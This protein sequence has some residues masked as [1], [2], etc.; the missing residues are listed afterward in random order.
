MK[1]GPPPKRKSPSP[2]SGNPAESQPEA[3]SFLNDIKNL[4]R[5]G[6]E[7]TQPT[8]AQVLA[9]RRGKEEV[10]TNQ[11]GAPAAVMNVDEIP[12]YDSN[13]LTDSDSE[14]S[15]MDMARES[16]NFNSRMSRRATLVQSTVMGLLENAR[17]SEVNKSMSALKKLENQSVQ[18]SQINLE[19]NTSP[20]PLN[21]RR[22]SVLQ[23]RQSIQ[24]KS[25]STS[26]HS[27]TDFIRG[28]TFDLAGSS[29][30]VSNFKPPGRSSTRTGRQGS[31]EE[32][33]FDKKDIVDFKTAPSH[34][35][36]GIL[37]SAIEEHE[38]EN[39]ANESDQLSKNSGN[40][41]VIN[42]SNFTPIEES[43]VATVSN[44]VRDILDV[45]S[46]YAGPTK[47]IKKKAGRGYGAPEDV[48]N[49]V[50]EAVHIRVARRIANAPQTLPLRTLWRDAPPA[51]TLKTDSNRSGNLVIPEAKNTSSNPNLLGFAFGTAR[52]DSP[53]S[54]RPGSIEVR[55][56]GSLAVYND[57]SGTYRT[58]GAVRGAQLEPGVT[59]ITLFAEIGT[60]GNRGTYNVGIQIGKGAFM[61]APGKAKDNFSF[62]VLPQ[63]P[64]VPGE[65]ASRDGK[66]N[67]SE[68][69]ADKLGMGLNKK[70]KFISDQFSGNARQPDFDSHEL[71]SAAFGTLAGIDSDHDEDDSPNGLSSARPR[72]GGLSM[73]D[74]R[75]AARSVALSANESMGFQPSD[76][77]LGKVVM[78]QIRI[79]LRTDGKIKF[80]LVDPSSG[81]K[82]SYSTNIPQCT[83]VFFEKITNNYGAYKNIPNRSRS[84]SPQRNRSLSANRD[85]DDQEKKNASTGLMEEPSLYRT[86]NLGIRRYNP[87][88]IKPLSPTR[89]SANNTLAAHAPGGEKILSSAANGLPVSL[90]SQRNKAADEVDECEA[91]RTVALCEMAERAVSFFSDL[92]LYPGE[93]SSESHALQAANEA[94]GKT[95]LGLQA[96]TSHNLRRGV[97]DGARPNLAAVVGGMAVHTL[98]SKVIAGGGG[99]N[100]NPSMVNMGWLTAVSS[101]LKERL[102]AAFDLFDVDQDGLVDYEEL[103]EILQACGF[104][105]VRKEREDVV[106]RIDA[107]GR[108]KVRLY[109]IGLELGSLLSHQSRV[110][111]NYNTNNLNSSTGKGGIFAAAKK[112]TGSTQSSCRLGAALE[113]LAKDT[114]NS[115]GIIGGGLGANEGSCVDWVRLKDL[116]TSMR[117]SL[118]LEEIEE[119]ERDL[120]EHGKV[121]V[122]PNQAGLSPSSKKLTGSLADVHKLTSVLL[123]GVG[124][125]SGQVTTNM[126]S[127]SSILSPHRLRSGLL[128][129]S[130]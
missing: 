98:E 61:I 93:W 9:D 34:S 80:N 71:S 35:A 73:R 70:G 23:R 72:L 74:I 121:F 45:E 129:G 14:L 104:E 115:N 10:F 111:N 24:R 55:P 60:A 22:Q 41:R 12:D 16:H 79:V 86:G 88:R 91:D 116:L 68:T 120:E 30:R 33:D 7:A 56:G 110:N 18:F 49:E 58:V 6:A 109:E 124:S 100:G 112:F 102:G 82:Y 26:R 77:K 8:L 1:M 4:R 117:D 39:S 54:K 15:N 21:P 36:M 11:Y 5:S 69:L 48:R 84:T 3:P 62:E 92:R 125:L 130:K 66:G 27:V 19:G 103:I 87:C 38:S 42:K 75:S 126:G 31:D 65:E 89:P 64:I 85:R 57:F 127:S 20:S 46:A 29:V 44:A 99:G 37:N 47:N 83:D 28:S 114:Y 50:R 81:R 96:K 13:A 2:G 106:K 67:E 118:T 40:K 97:T 107:G 95:S 51:G 53:L 32:A 122:S 105:L 90:A 108:G 119:I 63:Q 52:D 94:Q 76:E 128:N 59:A 25:I 101:E 17:A 113:S 78:H 123:Q 43:F